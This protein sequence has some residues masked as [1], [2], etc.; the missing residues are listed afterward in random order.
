MIIDVM[1]GISGPKPLRLEATQIVVY[2]DD[3]TPIMVAGEYGPKGAYRVAHVGDADFN[4]VLRA[5][6]V[7]RHEV[8]VDHID[9]ASVPSGARLLAGPT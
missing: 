3:G 5:F 9:R 4:Q 2:S 7:Q 8:V 1:N 6:G